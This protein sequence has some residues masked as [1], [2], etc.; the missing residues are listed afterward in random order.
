MR[1]SREQWSQIIGQF[2]ASGQSHEAFCAQQRLNVG[3][4]RGWLY[5]LRN[6]PM[7]GYVARSAT[8]LLPVRV[9]AAGAPDEESVIDVAEHEEPGK[10][11]QPGKGD[12]GLLLGWDQVSTGGFLSRRDLLRVVAS[13]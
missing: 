10:S 3:S 8:R 4:F 1:R 12:A 11:E 5:R 6:D 9:G 7:P 2:K 13:T